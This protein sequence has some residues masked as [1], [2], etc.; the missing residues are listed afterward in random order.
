MK[1]NRDV[2]KSRLSFAGNNEIESGS[3]NSIESRDIGNMKPESNEA[4]G[5]SVGK[6]RTNFTM[7]KDIAL[8][9]RRQQLQHITRSTRLIQ[10]RTSAKHEGTDKLLE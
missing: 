10:E 4:R 2:E 5:K 6:R 7:K 8:Q 3:I 1:L 9:L